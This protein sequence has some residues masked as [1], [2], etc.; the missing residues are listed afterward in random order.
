MIKSALTDGEMNFDYNELSKNN[1]NQECLDLLEKLSKKVITSQQDKVILP[2]LEEI[3]EELKE[4]RHW[5]NNQQP[6]LLSTSQLKSN[7]NITSNLKEF[8]CH[9]NEITQVFHFLVWIVS[10]RNK[11]QCQFTHYS[12]KEEQGRIL[13][14][15]QQQLIAHKNNNNN[16]SWFEIKEDKSKRQ[17]FVNKK[18]KSQ[19]SRQEQ[20]LKISKLL[21]DSDN[22]SEDMINLDRD[23]D[24]FNNEQLK[25]QNTHL[26]EQQ[27]YYSNSDIILHNFQL[28][29]L[30]I[31]ANQNMKA[32]NSLDQSYISEISIWEN[33]SRKVTNPSTNQ[34]I[35]YNWFE[36]APEQTFLNQ[37]GN[38]L[39]EN[40]HDDKNQQLLDASSNLKINNYHSIKN[41]QI[42]NFSNLSLKKLDEEVKRQDF[43]NQKQTHSKESF[44]K[45]IYLE[46]QQQDQFI[47]N[48]L[49][50]SQ[51]FFSD[52][53]QL[54]QSIPELEEFQVGSINNL[55]NS[56][57]QM[58]QPREYST[59]QVI[60]ITDESEDLD[61]LSI[62]EKIEYN[63]AMEE[64][65]I[66]NLN[67]QRITG[68]DVSFKPM[69][70][71]AQNFVAPKKKKKVKKL[72]RKPSE[73]QT[74]QSTLQQ[75]INDIDY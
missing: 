7:K 56:K 2:K 71:N 26:I 44:Q 74:P 17:R 54:H 62:R 14:Q 39:P 35:D 5:R 32:D 41:L 1:A 57:L 25:Q 16:T 61:Q 4:L 30:N 47:E 69:P 64:Q 59:Q 19:S 48:D 65:V 72:K 75:S 13:G 9:C 37:D 28:E 38:L 6:A 31:S 21:N 40:N 52:S 70:I 22:S 68:F 18:V 60:K 36:D 55:I 34:K 67:S 45:R 46:Y 3:Q 42:Q 23:D 10:T 49:E 33:E 51:N 73:K 63:A 15:N 58:V 8:R 24:Q 43:T 11:Q 29:K 66:Q 20:L 12:Q 50:S 53:S 27:P